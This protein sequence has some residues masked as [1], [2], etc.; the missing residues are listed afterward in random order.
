MQKKI[1]KLKKKE[2]PRCRIKQELHNNQVN[3][4]ND[5]ARRSRASQFLQKLVEKKCK[6]NSENELT[7]CGIEEKPRLGTN[8][9]TITDPSAIPAAGADTRK[10]AHLCCKAKQNKTNIQNQHQ[11]GSP[12]RTNKKPLHNP[13]SANNTITAAEHH[14]KDDA[15]ASH[16]VS[17][18][19]P[20]SAPPPSPARG[21]AVTTGSRLAL[22]CDIIA[23]VG[24]GVLSLSFLQCP[25][26]F[27][28]Y[29]YNNHI[30]SF[31]FLMHNNNNL[32]CGVFHYLK[33]CIIVWSIEYEALLMPFIK[34]DVPVFILFSIIFDFKC[35]IFSYFC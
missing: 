14:T 6:K 22:A 33:Y 10:A 9:G 12:L 8:S 2:L 18:A 34:W 15:A 29:F 31:K 25:L 30:R 20:S 28:F 17:E 7:K 32:I 3:T 24:L 35:D 27:F 19:P 5:D 16:R 4:K 13:H 1:A 11:T 21:P 26:T 23:R